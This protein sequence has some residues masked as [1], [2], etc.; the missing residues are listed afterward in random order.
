MEKFL[1]NE[2]ERQVEN[3][4][5]SGDE[6][7]VD[8]IAEN[9]AKNLREILREQKTN[10]TDPH[11]E[12]IDPDE[13]TNNALIIFDKFRKN[14]LMDKEFSEYRRNLGNYFRLQRQ[15]KKDKFNTLK[16]S[17]SNFSAMIANKIMAKRAEEMLRERKFKKAA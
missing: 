5:E 3:I 15:L 9:Y 17:R 2:N 1:K 8:E 14:A 10:K 4:F 13:L 7:N 6:V 12:N 16:D 11:L